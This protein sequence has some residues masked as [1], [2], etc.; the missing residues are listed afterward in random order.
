MLLDDIA[1]CQEVL[2]LKRGKP[3]PRGVELFQQ[4]DVLDEVLYV[5]TGIVKLERL[6]RDGLNMIVE[7]AFPCTWL[8]TAA[9]IAQMPSPVTAV[10]CTRTALAGMSA[11]V[12]RDLLHHDPA[13]SFRIH[14]MHTRELCRQTG[15][16]GQL[17]SANA[18][19]RL[20]RVIRQFI[21]ALRLP[22]SDRGTRLQLPLKQWELARLIA[23]TP[24]HLSRVLKDMEAEGMIR[25]D[26]GWVIV[27]DARRLCDDGDYDDA[28]WC[29]RLQVGTLET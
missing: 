2:R 19:E 16:I 3:Y 23:I 21:D 1:E 13:L 29:E 18:R 17:S 10:T 15:W 9:V 26:R 4:G 28:P 7:M 5:E 8:G 25:R 11:H 14:E 24:E 22:A 27:P 20:Q 6:D 12:F